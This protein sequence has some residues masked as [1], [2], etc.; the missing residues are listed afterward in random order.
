MHCL[1]FKSKEERTLPPRFKTK[2]NKLS[3]SRYC[4]PLIIFV[5]CK[6]D[7]IIMCWYTTV[8]WKTFPTS[9]LLLSDIELFSGQ[10]VAA[11]INISHATVLNSCK[12]QAENTE[13]E[14]CTNVAHS[15]HF[16]ITQFSD[17]QTWL[18]LQFHD[19]WTEY[20]A[21]QTQTFIALKL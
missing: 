8:L 19:K 16:A 10:R 13:R 2:Q 15:D 3:E 21:L 11:W 9:L 17:I 4:V 20:W 1:W 7:H 6:T 12:T 14:S 5:Q 18:S